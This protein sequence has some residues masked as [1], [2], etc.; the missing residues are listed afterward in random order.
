RARPRGS[1]D[2]LVRPPPHTVAMRTEHPDPRPADD[3][4]DTILLVG[5][6]LLAGVLAVPMM[7]GDLASELWH[8]ARN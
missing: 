4:R 8:R 3:A 5:G 6:L 7:V 2:A 1:T